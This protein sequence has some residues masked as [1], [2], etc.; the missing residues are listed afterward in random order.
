MGRSQL[1]NDPNLAVD[2]ALQGL[3][4]LSQ[5]RLTLLK[6]RIVVRSVVN[7]SKVALVSLGG[8]GHEPAHAG[9]VGVGMLTAAVAGNVFASPPPA[10]ILEALLHVTGPAGTIII[11]KNYTGD[12]V[13]AQRAK[14]QAAKEHGLRV[15]IV[16]CA[17]DC[18]TKDSA[19]GARGLAGTLFIHK[20][21][22]SM[23]ENGSSIDDLLQLNHSF[24]DRIRTMGLSFNSC[25]LPGQVVASKEIA[26][27]S[28]ELGLG[29]HGES[30]VQFVEKAPNSAEAA[31]MML[32]YIFNDRSSSTGNVAVLINNLGGLA[33]LEMLI[34]SNDVLKALSAR[35]V[36]VSFV[37]CGSFMTSLDSAG[38]SISLLFEATDLEIAALK[39]STT[40][41]GWPIPAV[42]TVEN[43][44]HV[45]SNDKPAM[46]T[47]S[48]K[49]MRLDKSPPV[50]NKIV[51][52]L[53]AASRLLHTPEVEKR[54]NDL[55]AVSGDGDTGNSVS[56]AAGLIQEE[57][58][59][60]QPRT[61]LELLKCAGSVFERMGG[62]LGGMM[63]M[64][65]MGA[66]DFGEDEVFSWQ[67]A[68]S[69]GRQA[70][71][72][73][74]GANI[75][76]RSMVDSLY[77]AIENSHSALDAAKAARRGANETANMVA[78][79][80]RAS[81]VPS[82][83]YLSYNDPGAEAVALFLEAFAQSIL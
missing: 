13:N 21:L 83:K 58:T 31:K 82:Q 74:G 43:A 3:V 2:Q 7:K 50:E 47:A 19:I 16:V 22:G 54:L 17:D 57:L 29:I 38:A 40:S 32:S 63:S 1:I 36:T 71:Q 65:F 56:R 39:D 33:V 79:V 75:G 81:Y 53:I 6:P 41:L 28:A 4:A 37:A 24:R 48:S 70:V 25:A 69:K 73:N 35:H 15:E 45:V 11:V 52:A 5:E 10:D 67:T 34:F 14:D 12:I 66:Q 76:N 18:A 46:A 55:D 8:S 78:K 72:G 27:G 23:A 77:P 42:V 49:R 51:S 60:S 68:W 20:I 59:L 44:V 26:A 80:G 62:S 9:Y 64:F 30:G 61:A